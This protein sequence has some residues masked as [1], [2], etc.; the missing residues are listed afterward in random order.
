[1]EE[2]VEEKEIFVGMLK[3]SP[4]IF[5]I[6]EFVDDSTLKNAC[7]LFEIPTPDQRGVM[8]Q[9]H[10]DPYFTTDKEC[11]ICTSDYLMYRIETDTEEKLVREYE[12]LITNVR[13]QKAGIVTPLHGIRNANTP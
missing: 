9:F 5:I 11:T 7:R 10:P 3:Y 4:N 6:G 13:M 1:M 12:Q 8:Y 2:E